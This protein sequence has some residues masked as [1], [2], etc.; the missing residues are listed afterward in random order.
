[1]RSFSERSPIARLGLYSWY[2]SSRGAFFARTFNRVIV[3][4]R[5]N[6]TSV[7]DATDSACLAARCTY[8]IYDSPLIRSAIYFAAN[9]V[10]D[11]RARET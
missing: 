10:F 2:T 11:Y 6:G 5:E 9:C 3:S 1:M 4:S 8:G 7:L